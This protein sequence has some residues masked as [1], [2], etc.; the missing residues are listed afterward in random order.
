MTTTAQQSPSSIVDNLLGNRNGSTV[1]IDPDK[2]ALQLAATGFIPGEMVYAR[3]WPSLSAMA[4]ARNG[5]GA[6]VIETDNGTHL[7]ATANGY[8]GAVVPNA[9]R[10]IYSTTWGRWVRIGASGLFRD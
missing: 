7:D 3:D 6:E 10:Y 2:L 9:G 5:A 8:N 4:G 1:R